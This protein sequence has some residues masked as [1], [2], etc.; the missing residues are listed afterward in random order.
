MQYAQKNLL[1]AAEMLSTN[2]SAAF[3]SLP[4][5]YTSIENATAQNL[6]PLYHNWLY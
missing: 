3:S 2:N 5:P 1:F 6:L 4:G